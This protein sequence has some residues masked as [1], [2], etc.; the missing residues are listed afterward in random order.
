M[1][2]D[3]SYSCRSLWKSRGFTL[4]AIT[5]LA[6][7]IGTTTSIFTL[8]YNTMFRPLP[9]AD[10][11]RLVR[12]IWRWNKGYGPGVVPVLADAVAQRTR[13]FLSVATVFP[14]AGCNL[15][16]G[17]A[18]EYAIDHKVSV[19]FFRTLGVKLAAG[20]DFI[21]EDGSG[22]ESSVAII[23]YPLWQRRFQGVPDAVG[24]QLQC[25][26]QPFTIIGVLPQNFNYVKQGDVWLPA[27]LATY[28]NDQGMNY[29]VIARLRPDVDV[30]LAQQDLNSVFQQLRQENPGRW[31]TRQKSGGMA[32]LPYRQWQFGDLRKPIIVLSCAV[33]LVLL[34]ACA[35]MAGLLLVRANAR[36]HET[37]IRLALGA[38]RTQL[39]RQSFTETTFLSVLGGIAGIVLAWW[40]LHALRAIIP[41]GAKFLGIEQLNLLALGIN[42][43]VGLFAFLLS[44]LTGLVS[45]LIPA[46]A[47]TSPKLSNGLK[48][49]ERVAGNNRG[50]Q[51]SRKLLLSAEV[52]ISLMLLVG[53]M[54]LIRSFVQ[55]QG[56]R[57][58]FDPSNLQVL[59]LSYASQKY[60]SPEAIAGFEEKTAERI[61]SLPGVVGAASV[62]SAPLQS[63]LNLPS[64]EVNGKECTSDGTVDY[65]A[66]SP[67]YFG[68]MRTPILRGREFQLQDSATSAPVVVVNETFARM[69]WP[70]QSPIGQQV[71]IGK[72]QGRLEDVP[73]EIV[74][75]VADTREYALDMASPPVAFVPQTQVKQNINELLYHSFNLISAVMIRTSRPTDLSLGAERTV[76]SVDPEQPVVSI[77]PMQQVVG[78]SIAFSR[79]LMLLMAVFAGLAL[80]LTMVGLYGLF[81]YYVT[82]R[83]Q[84]IGVR[85]ALG[86]SRFHILTLVL[87]EGFLLALV[88]GLIGVA[89]AFVETRFLRN[90]L[91]GITPADP[92]AFVVSGAGLLMVILLASYLP[93]RRAMAVDPMIVLRYE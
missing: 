82:L 2:R 19:D 49:G 28:F 18:A 25:N 15:A 4:V 51:R 21:P 34:I 12:I 3:L 40:Q 59:Q 7:G 48:Q 46:L 64:P 10:S 73:R 86:A 53:A 79:L 58:G 1:I 29:G 80:L 81:S 38:K 75:V 55:L 39:L 88:G 52:S 27:N 17:G 37:S 76:T 41:A 70:E 61:R 22:K 45:G 20:R 54:L 44:L 42:L 5:T 77:M 62:S 91:F 69:C 47:L 35:N 11:D 50:E 63:G 9:Y 23:S 72:N 16:G 30:V 60:K 74:G 92:V 33:V 71:W 57:L 36:M 8:V 24:K 65:R 68:V 83:T 85:M 14:S 84:E 32:A 66:V 87:R 93:A 6:L 56:V 67:G 31:W 26:G 90:L 13:S 43:P 89:G 78:D